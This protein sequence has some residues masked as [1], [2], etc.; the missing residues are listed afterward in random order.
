[1]RHA[2]AGA[3]ESAFVARAVEASGGARGTSWE[4]WDGS[5][6]GPG[7]PLIRSPPGPSLSIEV[8]DTDGDA[9][10]PTPHSSRVNL[11]GHGSRF[12]QRAAREHPSREV[13]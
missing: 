3:V 9:V 6:R 10:L 2:D 12:T 11:V 1:M 7:V 13:C 5:A 4:A 8:L